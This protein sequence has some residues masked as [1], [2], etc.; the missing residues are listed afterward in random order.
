[1]E[2]AISSWLLA[3]RYWLLAKYWW[4]RKSAKANT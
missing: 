3:V 4:R 2:K 1:M